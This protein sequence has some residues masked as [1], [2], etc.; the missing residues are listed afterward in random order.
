MQHV[1]YVSVNI[2]RGSSLEFSESQCLTR[3]CD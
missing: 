2:V 3:L 1:H